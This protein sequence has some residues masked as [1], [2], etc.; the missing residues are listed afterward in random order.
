[1][2]SYLENG[3]EFAND[4]GRKGWH[5]S[6]F[7]RIKLTYKENKNGNSHKSEAQDIRWSDKY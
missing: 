7:N 3:W 5:G 4:V 2:T 6:H 1:M